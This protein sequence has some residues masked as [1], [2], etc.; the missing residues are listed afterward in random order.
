MARNGGDVEG[1]SGG[2]ANDSSAPR[3]EDLAT[4]VGQL[5]EL[6]LA[7]LHPPRVTRSDEERKIGCLI[8]SPVLLGSSSSLGVHARRPTTTHHRTSSHIRPAAMARPT[9]WARK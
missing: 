9:L 4:A 5:F 1:S 8:S 3:D 7:R 2:V 6:L